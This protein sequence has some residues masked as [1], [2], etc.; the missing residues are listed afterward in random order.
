MNNKDI[1]NLIKQ[2][3]EKV[4]IKDYSQQ[5]VYSANHEIKAKKNKSYKLKLAIGAVAIMACFILVLIPILNVFSKVKIMEVGNAEKVFSKEIIA[6][7][8]FINTIEN[9]DD[10]SLE[11]NSM[12]YYEFN[13]EEELDTDDDNENE[14]DLDE[15]SNAELLNIEYKQIAKELHSYITTSNILLNKD[16][17]INYENNKDK[18]YKEYEYKIKV[19]TNKSQYIAYYNEKKSNNK[20]ICEGVVLMD[21]KQFILNSTKKEKGNE[22]ITDTFIH[23]KNNKIRITNENSVGENEFEYEYYVGNQLIKAV[24]YS[25]EEENGVISTEIEI[26]NQDMTVAYTIEQKHDS[27]ICSY[28]TE[29]IECE[30]LVDIFEEYYLYIFEDK[31]EIKIVV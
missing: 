19:V 6:A 20:L 8:N 1:K 13:K 22:T 24:E 9:W 5:I 2:E 31:T 10:L 11:I 12:S 21:N 7:G 14:E 27:I 4:E 17:Q 3:A 26:K 23:Y 25:T 15:D 30:I 29:E 16:Y 18:E 28:E